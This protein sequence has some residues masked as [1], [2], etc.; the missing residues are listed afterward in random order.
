MSWEEALV[1]LKVLLWELLNIDPVFSIKEK[2]VF[3]SRKLRKF[4]KTTE[5]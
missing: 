4:K 5:D 2:R 3:G 1:S